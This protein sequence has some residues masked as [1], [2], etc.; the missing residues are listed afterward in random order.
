MSR[1]QLKR[2]ID[3]AYIINRDFEIVVHNEMIKGVS[4]FNLS[5]AFLKTSIDHLVIFGFTTS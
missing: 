4:D 1:S 5:Q 2:S 3:R